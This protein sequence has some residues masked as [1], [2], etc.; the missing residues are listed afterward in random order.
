VIPIINP[1]AVL[2]TNRAGFI[3]S[4]NGAAET[5]LGRPIRR[6]A[7]LGQITV[8]FVKGRVEL[9]KALRE[10]YPGGAA[11]IRTAWISPTGRT[12]AQVTVTMTGLDD[13]FRWVLRP[14]ST[15]RVAGGPVS[16]S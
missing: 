2:I 6:P 9:R 8:L 11:V 7:R 12:M 10:V 4:M 1:D 15:C 3:Q 14:I 16:A 13:G 5:L